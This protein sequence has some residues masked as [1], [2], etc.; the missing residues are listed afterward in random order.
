MIDCSKGVQVSEVF[1]GEKYSPLLYI[2]AENTLPNCLSSVISDFS[3]IL[4]LICLLV[5][6]QDQGQCCGWVSVGYQ[7]G[8]FCFFFRCVAY[9]NISVALRV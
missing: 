3:S 1:I 7:G 4:N 9:F 8:G 6:E 5:L 2:I